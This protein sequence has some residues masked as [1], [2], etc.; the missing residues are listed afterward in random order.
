MDGTSINSSSNIN[1]TA[2]AAA[3]IG[4][5]TRDE[6]RAES[7]RHTPGCLAGFPNLSTARKKLVRFLTC[8]KAPNHSPPPS[9]IAPGSNAPI[10]NPESSAPTS[11]PWWEV[12]YFP[13]GTYLTPGDEM[14]EAGGKHYVAFDE[15]I[16]CSEL[17]K[18]AFV[19]VDERLADAFRMLKEVPPQHHRRYMSSL[20][21]TFQELAG[22][23]KVH[24]FFDT[25]CRHY[26]QDVPN[27]PRFTEVD[28]AKMLSEFCGMVDGTAENSYRRQFIDHL[29][30][31]LLAFARRW[32]PKDEPGKDTIEALRAYAVNVFGTISNSLFYSKILPEKRQQADICQ[33]WFQK[34]TL[35]G[36]RLLDWAPGHEEAALHLV[37]R[38]A[39]DDV[40]QYNPDNIRGRMVDWNNKN[41][42]S[43]P[44]GIET[45]R[46]A[47]HIDLS[48]NRLVRIP[49][50]MLDMTNEMNLRK[51]IKIDLTGNPLT[52][53][54]LEELRQLGDK[55]RATG[56]RFT[57]PQLREPEPM[58]TPD[59][60][61]HQMLGTAEDA[62][63][64]DLKKAYQRFSLTY[65]PD[66]WTPQKSVQTGLTQAQMEEKFKIVA[67]LYGEFGNR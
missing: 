30:D 66:K 34:K 8:Y 22:I 1:N 67:A 47:S 24:A 51:R 31:D 4:G 23:K 60:P 53:M 14:H 5:T 38:A 39:S 20:G 65:H 21:S 11:K 28:K 52:G 64:V 49:M 19:N 36:V 35:H 15:C 26:W 37:I 62:T 44:E 32:A 46:F 41:L 40:M 18:N 48:G 59:T 50:A 54:T 9:G 13:L 7:I 43:L 42:D 61:L 27:D 45:M 57:V 16:G 55:K 12:K 63:K 33:Y 2:A 29:P 10:T 58:P 3:S 6:P 17:R 25:L 56:P